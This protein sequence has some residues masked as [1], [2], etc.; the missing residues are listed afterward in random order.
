MLTVPS[1]RG[2]MLEHGPRHAIHA[3]IARGNDGNRL[4]SISKLGS[5]GGALHLLAQWH[6]EY[7]LAF[8]KVAHLLYIAVIAHD[9][10]ASLQGIRS[11]RRQ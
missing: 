11:G 3:Y 8:H 6:R 2:E 7:L 1:L 4:A 9:D 5:F 10:I